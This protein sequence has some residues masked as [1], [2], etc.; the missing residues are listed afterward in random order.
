MHLKAMNLPCSSETNVYKAGAE[1]LA[2]DRQQAKQ[3]NTN[4]VNV[5]GAE[6]NQ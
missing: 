6:M 4:P 5:L 2:I 1:N 3:R